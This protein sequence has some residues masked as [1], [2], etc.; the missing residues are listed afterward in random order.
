[1]IYIYGSVKL[2]QK[3]LVAQLFLIITRLQLSRKYDSIDF[4]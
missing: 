3:K 1:L 4:I 2:K